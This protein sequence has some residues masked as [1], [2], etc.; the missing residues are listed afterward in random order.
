MLFMVLLAALALLFV[1]GPLLWRVRASSA[2]EDSVNASLAWYQQRL[3]LLAEE[4]ADSVSLAEMEEELAAV[5]LAE[6][7]QEA[8]ARGT[9]S[10]SSGAPRKCRH[11]GA[12][13]RW[14]SAEAHDQAELQ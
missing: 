1:I 9:R 13:K 2:R 14:G 11:R 10:K 12:R 3:S 8:L 6:H 7:P 4:A 5:L